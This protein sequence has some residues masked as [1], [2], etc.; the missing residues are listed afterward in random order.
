MLNDYIVHTDYMIHGTE[1]YHHIIMDQ[2]IVHVI[3]NG[4]NG[5]QIQ[6]TAAEYSTRR[7]SG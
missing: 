1:A 6:C 5:P 7:I 4:T 2:G 3:S